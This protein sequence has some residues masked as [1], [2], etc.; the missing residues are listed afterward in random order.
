[1]VV[2]LVFRD[3]ERDAGARVGQK[4]EFQRDV[5]IEQPFI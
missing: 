4:G 2:L 3:S 1:M 5:I